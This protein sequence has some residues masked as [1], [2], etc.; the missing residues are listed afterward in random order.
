VTDRVVGTRA[1]ELIFALVN[2]IGT[3]LD[4]MRRELEGGL[5]A[6]GYQTEWVKLSALLADHAERLGVG[7]VPATPEHVRA[8]KFMAIG[9][10]LCEEAGSSAA[11]AL[12][13]INWIRIKR[14]EAAA[15]IPS[16]EDQDPP[17]LSRH[18]FILDSLKRPAEVKQLR[19]IYGDHLIVMSL[20]AGKQLREK[21]L[22]EKIS[23][24]AV[25]MDATQ[26]DAVIDDLVMR[27]LDDKTKRHGQNI[28]KTFPMGDVFISV[29]SNATKQVHR[30][31]D[32][33][34][35]NPDYPVP[36]NE[37]FGMHLAY[38]AS[39][40]SPELGLKVGAAILEKATVV[41]MGMNSHPTEQSISPAFDSSATDIRQ[42]ILDT[43][44][45][46]RE[47]HLT[48]NSG[49]ALLGDPDQMVEELMNGPLKGS[50]IAS[51]TEFQPTVH[52][53][54]AAILDATQSGKSISSKAV[55]YVTTFPCHGC[56]KH[57]L[58]L[59]VE[60]KYIEPY[61]KGRAQ[62]MYGIDAV[63][64]FQPFTGIAPRRYQL[65]F[66]ATEDRKDLWGARKSWSATE[67]REAE[68]NVDPMIDHS[69]VSLRE[70]YA[71]AQL[72]SAQSDPQSGG[73]Q[74]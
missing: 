19:Q 48:T 7:P 47:A 35:G 39:T 5:H 62:A 56:A 16:E 33:L 54:M 32:L 50:Q 58:R 41:S 13:A 52:A 61:P 64:S 45:R 72:V 2:P 4:E 69:G 23:P 26:L 14:S 12:E 63:A 71:L 36:T 57:L 74:Q 40:R 29:E 66:T 11:V 27:D 43:L 8:G 3:P 31:L 59:G 18:A 30:L 70:Q 1:P 6:Y 49:Q 73:E 20:Q 53:E 46:L 34:F 60:V 55:V 67:K 24:Y 51:L 21:T 15:A 22:R 65:L 10:S 44:S 68:P 38:L 37:E 9:D 17:E 42:L 25:S 28:L